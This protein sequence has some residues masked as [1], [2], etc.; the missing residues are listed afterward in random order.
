MQK[1]QLKDYNVKAL[2]VLA[3]QTHD[4]VLYNDIKNILLEKY[5]SLNYAIMYL[6][7][8]FVTSKGIMREVYAE[9]IMIIVVTRNLFIFPN[10]LDEIISLVSMDTLTK[11]G[12]E[13][14]NLEL[15]EKCKNE[16]W[17]RALD[18]EK[19]ACLIKKKYI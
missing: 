4:E 18:E 6:L 12:M 1:P 5:M 15:S 7:N 17:K 10:V 16:F 2:I 14:N 9:I 3:N 13:C 8:N 19:D 11:Y